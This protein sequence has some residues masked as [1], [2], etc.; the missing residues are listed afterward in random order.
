MNLLH[1]KC[2]TILYI[3]HLSCVWRGRWFCFFQTRILA[4]ACILSAHYVRRQVR[5]NFFIAP[6]SLSHLFR[7]S[8]FFMIHTAG[9]A[10]STHNEFL[11]CEK[12]KKEKTLRCVAYR[13]RERRHRSN[14]ECAVATCYTAFL[15]VTLYIS[16]LILEILYYR[17][18]LKLQQYLLHFRLNFCSK[19]SIL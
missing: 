2:C 7:P 6:K 9:G 12:R 1:Q 4:P 5:M 15:Q 11:A 18:R 17:Y 19:R 13:R 10:R 8:A 3:P 14:F 16:S